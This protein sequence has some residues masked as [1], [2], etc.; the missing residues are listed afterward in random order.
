MPSTTFLEWISFIFLTTW[1]QRLSVKR[2]IQKIDRRA[3][4]NLC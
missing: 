2:D 1:D 4:Y 3:F